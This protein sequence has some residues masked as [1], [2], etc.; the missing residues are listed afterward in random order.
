MC[1]LLLKAYIVYFIGIC[2]LFYYVGC[3]SVTRNWT[4][5]YALLQSSLVVQITLYLLPLNSSLKSADLSLSFLFLFVFC[6]LSVLGLPEEAILVTCEALF[7]LLLSI[8]TSSAAEKMFPLLG[9]CRVLFFTEA[10]REASW[11]A[12]DT[13]GPKRPTVLPLKYSFDLY[14]VQTQ[15]KKK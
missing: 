6:P 9:Q 11:S 2:T 13:C 3:C 12:L 1:W 7:N 10:H 4:V 8:A 15:R 14:T 5:L